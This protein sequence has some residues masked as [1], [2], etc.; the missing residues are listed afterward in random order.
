MAACA[1]SGSGKPA[2]GTATSA[3][4]PGQAVS[5]SAVRDAKLSGEDIVAL[6]HAGYKIV[7]Q[8]GEKL[9]CSTDPKTGSRIVH[10]NT[11]MTEKEM[12]AL[13][14]ETK[15]RM[16]NMMREQPPPQGN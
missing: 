15:R 11:C 7:D 3:A 13:R 10:D 16:Q 8:N 2:G 12:V 6:Q 9:Y 5:R 14:E 4:A 1:S